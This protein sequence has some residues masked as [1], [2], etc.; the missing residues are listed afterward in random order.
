MIRVN[1]NIFYLNTNNTSYVFR[2]MP[3]GHL[4][5][6]YYGKRIN[7]YESSEVFR[8]KHANQN[9]SAILYDKAFPTVCMNDTNLEV[10]G[11]G[12]GDMR[13]PSIELLWPD[14]YN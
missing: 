14:G 7:D 10:S 5:H 4:E 8:T 11:R 6:L 9:G 12:T 1:D 2:I 13:A 3:T